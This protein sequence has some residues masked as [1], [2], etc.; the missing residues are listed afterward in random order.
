MFHSFSHFYKMIL[1]HD[2]EIYTRIL[3]EVSF[4]LSAQNE[5]RVLTGHVTR[6]QC[7]V[8]KYLYI[9]VVNIDIGSYVILPIHMGRKYRHWVVCHITYSNIEVVNIDFG[10]YVIL[11]IHTGRWYRLWVVC[12]MSYHLYIRVFNIDFG[13][14]VILPIHT[15]HIYRHW[16]ECHITYTYRS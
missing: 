14:C 13:S 15:G 7:V 6:P 10:S 12:H 3:S 5:V 4:F 16:V 2:V 1:Y 9:Q 11:P 8:I